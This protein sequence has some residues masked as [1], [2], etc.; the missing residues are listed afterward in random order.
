[1]I[2]TQ[3][4]NDPTFVK[5]ASRTTW[6][7]ARNKAATDSL[8]SSV[9]LVFKSIPQAAVSKRVARGPNGRVVSLISYEHVPHRF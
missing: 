4:R 8:R 3:E 9:W 6:Q 1:M 5:H 7:L 2:N